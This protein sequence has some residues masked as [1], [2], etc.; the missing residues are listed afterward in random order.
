MNAGRISQAVLQ[1][2][3]Q[4]LDRE[5]KTKSFTEVESAYRQII[6][7]LESHGDL[8]QVRE[9]FRKEDDF[10]SFG[11]LKSLERAARELRSA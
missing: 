10:V 4:G 2:A 8:T 3:R 7:R 11:L 5:T 1:L 6:Y 9:A